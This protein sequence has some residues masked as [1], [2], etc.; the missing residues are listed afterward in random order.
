WGISS[1]LKTSSSR[2]TI[3]IP[4]LAVEAL[5][6]HKAAQE[7]EALRLGLWLWDTHKLGLVFPGLR[8]DPGL[9]CTLHR[10]YRRV[11][12]RAGVPVRR[13]HDTRHT[14]ASLMM[15]M[16]I[17]IKVISQI[18]GHSSTRVTLDIYAHL[19]D[20]AKQQAADK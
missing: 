5:R 9:E 7:T 14:A 20:E 16:G 1:L 19:Y 4:P 10:S 18:L 15:A 2:R 3:N 11:L 17:P 6:R 13:F 8:G 12:E